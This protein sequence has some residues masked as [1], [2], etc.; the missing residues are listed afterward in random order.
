MDDLHFNNI[1]G[2]GTKGGQNVSSI[3]DPMIRAQFQQHQ[4]SSGSISGGTSSS[5]P[6]F[7]Q[8]QSSPFNSTSI[9]NLVDMLNEDTRNQADQTAVKVSGLNESFPTVGGGVSGSTPA[10]Q[11]PPQDQGQQSQQQQ[12]MIMAA[13]VQHEQQQQQQQQAQHYQFNQQQGQPLPIQ[14]QQQQQQQNIQST[15]SSSEHMI[16]QQQQIQNFLQMHGHRLTQQLQ[17]SLQQQLAA[18]QQRQ[19]QQEMYGGDSSSMSHNVQV[20]GGDELGISQKLNDLITSN[21]NLG[22]PGNDSGTPVLPTVYQQPGGFSQP[23]GGGNGGG[24]GSAMGNMAIHQR[25]QLQQLQSIIDSAPTPLASQNDVNAQLNS[26][27]GHLQVATMAQQQQRMMQE[28][29]A[30]KLELIRQLQHQNQAA[31]QSPQVV[32]NPAV[33]KLGSQLSGILPFQQQHQQLGKFGGGD[34]SGSSALIQQQSEL[35]Q[36][37]QQQQQQRLMMENMM[38]PSLSPSP[39]PA[40]PLKNSLGGSNPFLMQLQKQATQGQGI[41]QETQQNQKNQQGNYN[42]LRQLQPQESFT[43]WSNT[44]ITSRPPPGASQPSASTDGTVKTATA[45]HVVPISISPPRVGTSWKSEKTNSGAGGFGVSDAVLIY[46]KYALQSIITSLN[47]FSVKSGCSNIERGEKPTSNSRVY[48]V[49]DLSTCIGAWDLKVPAGN[50]RQRGEGDSKTESNYDGNADTSFR[51]YYERSCPILLNAKRSQTTP[52]SL[53]YC[54]EDFGD[55]CERRMAGVGKEG[56]LV[57]DLGDERNEKVDDDQLPV[58]AG[59]IVLKYGSDSKFTGGIGEEGVM[60]KAI[61]EFFYNG[62]KDSEKFGGSVDGGC[63]MKGEGGDDKHQEVKREIIPDQDAMINAE[64]QLFTSVNVTGGDHESSSLIKAAL[65]ALSPSLTTV[66]KSTSSSDDG[67]YIPTIWSGNTNRTYQ[68]CLL[69]N[70]DNIGKELRSKRFCVAVHEKNKNE[71]DGESG[72]AKGVCRISLTLSPTSVLMKKK[73]MAK[74]VL[75]EAR[76]ENNSESTI[77]LRNLTMLSTGSGVHRLIRTSL[78]V[79]RP[80]KLTTFSD[81]AAMLPVSGFAQRRRSV[82]QTID[83]NLIVVGVRCQHELL[84][85]PIEAGKIYINGAL[86]VDCSSSTYGLNYLGAD[87]LPTHTLFGVDFTLPVGDG[88]HSIGSSSLPMKIILE[89]EYGSLLVDALIDAAQYD[90]NVAGKLLGRLITGNAEQ[91]NDIDQDKNVPSTL[92]STVKDLCHDSLPFT[93]NKTALEFDNVSQPCM[94]SFVLSSSIID[95]VGIGAKALGTRF[96][97]QYGKD[98]FPCEVGTDDEQRLR[99][100]LGS[101]KMPKAVPHRARTVLLRGGYLTI[102]QTVSSLWVRASREHRSSMPTL[103]SC[104]ADVKIHAIELLEKAGCWDVKLDNILLVDRK[105]LEPDVT[106]LSEF[107]LRCWCDR[108]SGIYY[109]SD[110]ILQIKKEREGSANESKGHSLVETSELQSNT[111]IGSKTYPP[112]GVSPLDINTVAAPLFAPSGNVNGIE[113]DGSPT[114]AKKILTDNVRKT[115]VQAEIVDGK[116]NDGTKELS[117]DAFVLSSHGKSTH[118]EEVPDIAKICTPSVST[119]TADDLPNKYSSDSTRL[120][121]EEGYFK[122]STFDSAYLLAFYIAKEHPDCTMLERFVLCHH[123]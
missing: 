7:R 32:N 103:E 116:S 102:D 39:M 27:Q 5:T 2:G 110:A 78:R 69:D 83:P 81:N 85:D 86:A 113:T 12:R 65:Y 74:E 38:S 73:M 22:V 23:W 88:K 94:E 31:V 106:Q 84:L 20:G 41:S 98:A 43:G 16:A 47:Q 93:E 111:M 46:T 108:D 1:N 34:G 80:P 122:A 33:G 59:A 48:S 57:G 9:R 42:I 67:V 15:P 51:Y 119:V 95:P 21:T 101:C 92:A 117:K 4:Q 71:C 100:I 45:I 61:I 99:Q 29:Q 3:N 8:G 17:M 96:R 58:L 109:V 114:N 121:N 104:Y 56:G 37:L 64:E 30:R 49:R 115:D 14:N 26:M 19:Q 123:S 79:L 40:I 44:A 18:L 50:K 77:D 107:R 70:L 90:C 120:V 52:A 53:P 82:T 105:L 6:T 66:A 28:S 55:A 91:V 60:T 75:E 89:R 24:S 54:V 72:P 97:M 87:T 35:Q 25:E 68:Y 63:G 112:P 36:R 62:A 118:G 11:Q 76:W 10:W 13:I